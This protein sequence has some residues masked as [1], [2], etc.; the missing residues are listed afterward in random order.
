VALCEQAACEAVEGV[1]P[2]GCTTVGTRVQFDHLAPVKVGGTVAAEAVLERAEGR[3]LTFNVTASDTSG[4]V[5]A[6]RMTRVV[7]DEKR[8]LAKVR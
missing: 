4:L 8:F 3:R 2:V 5:G 1:V 7:V 6:G